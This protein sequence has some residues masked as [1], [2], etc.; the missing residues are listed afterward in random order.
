[1]SVPHSQW[2]V[3]SD[4]SFAS[5]RLA[6]ESAAFIAAPLAKAL[7]VAYGGVTAGTY[8]V[9]RIR[10]DAEAI[11]AHMVEIYAGVTAP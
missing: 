9:A 1:M 5:I 2:S 6:L 7:E 4:E 3:E 11:A 8:T 10:R